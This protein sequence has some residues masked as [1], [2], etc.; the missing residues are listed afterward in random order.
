M[1]RLH[2]SLCLDLSVD[3]DWVEQRQSTDPT[4]RLLLAVVR[5]A[6]W[7]FVLYKDPTAANHELAVDAA[8][9]LFWDGQEE[10]DEEGRY[11]FLYI[12]SILGIDPKKVRDHA[13][14]LTRADIQKMNTHLG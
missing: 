3:Q 8:G 7:D 1:E 4:Q 9:W 12:C 5:R 10:E 2:L 6:V 13:L 11:S 14:R